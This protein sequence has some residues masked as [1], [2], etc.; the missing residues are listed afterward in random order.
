MFESTF[1]RETVPTDSNFR[2]QR[3]P[4]APHGWHDAGPSVLTQGPWRGRVLHTAHCARQSAACT[5]YAQLVNDWLMARPSPI[6]ERVAGGGPPS[7]NIANPVQGRRRQAGMQSN[8][9][10]VSTRSR[11][12]G[13]PRRQGANRL[14]LLSISEGSHA[15]D[16][17][18][19]SAVARLP[20]D[21]D[22]HWVASRS[23][24]R[25]GCRRRR[26]ATRLLL[27]HWWVSRTRLEIKV[28]PVA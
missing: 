4:K 18:T 19:E 24:S 3:M 13:Q 25:F 15:D 21:A 28:S 8:R 27:A 6:N 26:D 1:S 22:G 14:N 10:E 2:P 16:Q 5:R 17:S 12:I 20:L 11:P 23:R 9:V 7:R